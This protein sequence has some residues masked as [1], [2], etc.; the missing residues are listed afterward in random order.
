MAPWPFKKTVNQQFKSVQLKSVHKIVY[1]EE[2][3]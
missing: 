1:T 3:T 2:L